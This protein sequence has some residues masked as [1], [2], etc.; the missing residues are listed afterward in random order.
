MFSRYTVDFGSL[1]RTDLVAG[2]AVVA[3]RGRLPGRHR[4]TVDALLIE[5]EGLGNRDLP[6]FDQGPVRVAACARLRHLR[7]AGGCPGILLRQQFMGRAVTVPTLGGFLHAL[8][9]RFPVHARLPS[10]HHRLVARLADRRAELCGP[11]H[12]MGAVAALAVELRTVL[13]TVDALGKLPA[14]RPVAAG[15]R[16]RRNLLG[17]GNLLDA[18][19]AGGAGQAAV[20]GGLEDA[21]VGV[22]GDLLA[23]DLFDQPLVRV[24]AQTVLVGRPRRRRHRQPDEAKRSRCP[25][26][27]DP[28]DSLHRPTLHRQGMSRT[29]RIQTG[30]TC[31]WRAPDL[32]T[33]APGKTN[34]ADCTTSARR[35]PDRIRLERLLTAVPATIPPVNWSLRHTAQP[36]RSRAE[37]RLN[38]PREGRGRLVRRAGRAGRHRGHGESRHG[39]AGCRLVAEVRCRRGIRR[40]A[41]DRAAAPRRSP[42]GSPAGRAVRLPPAA[43]A[44]DRNSTVPNPA[45]GLNALRNGVIRPSKETT[46]PSSSWIG[47]S[48]TT[49][50]ARSVAAVLNRSIAAVNCARGEAGRKS[51]DAR[52]VHAQQDDRLE[53]PGVEQA[54][55]PAARSAG[56]AKP[57]S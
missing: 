54:P 42:G 53:L 7:P 25:R 56:L 2:V 5:L 24:T 51:R 20:D 22:E 8:R 46:L 57:P 35:S 36:F 16:H 17:V 13:A 44:S 48:G 21:L 31:I 30:S 15:A 19:V 49:T 47:H 1:A 43:S 14:G 33:P 37:L 6:L 4:P 52:R 12:D 18:R 40:R 23:S 11:L 39:A 50:S 29:M 45:S 41:S 55:S 3:R 26:K 27:Q 10:L 32:P 34:R 38:H 28:Q 9:H